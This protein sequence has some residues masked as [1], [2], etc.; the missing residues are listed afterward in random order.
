M[1]ATVESAT[2]L[3]EEGSIDDIPSPQ[4]IREERVPSP[5]PQKMVPILKGI[6]VPP[7]EGIVATEEG[8]G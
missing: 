7:M 8:T 6:I 1:E 5:F 4:E 3:V 2:E